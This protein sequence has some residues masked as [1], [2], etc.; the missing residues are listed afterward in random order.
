MM[1]SVMNNPE[2]LRGMMMNNPQMQQILQSNPQVVP[3]DPRTSV[4]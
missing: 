2:L 3:F 1:Q 4:V